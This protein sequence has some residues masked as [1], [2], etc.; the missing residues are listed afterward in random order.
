M[1]RSGAGD[2]LGFYRLFARTPKTVSL[3]CQGI[4]QSNQGWT[5]PTPSSTP[6]CCAGASASRGGPFSMT[7]QP[8]AMGGREVGAGDPAGGPHGLWRG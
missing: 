3:F 7:G 2:L 4:N 8:N 1:L 6:I 5:R